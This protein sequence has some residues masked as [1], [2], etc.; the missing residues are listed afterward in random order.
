MRSLFRSCLWLLL[1]FAPLALAWSAPLVIPAGSEATKDITA[2]NGQVE[3]AGHARESVVL[4]GGRLK[5]TGT[6]DKDVICVG[7]D[8][9]IGES[10]IIGQDLIVIGGTLNKSDDCKI[11]GKSIYLRTRE[12]MLAFLQ[13]MLPFLPSAGGM[14]L[15]R[16]MKIVLFLILSLL[17]LAIVQNHVRQ[18]LTMFEGRIA[19]FTVIGLIGLVIF[20]MMLIFATILSFFLIG[21]PILLLLI[22]F[23]FLTLIFGRTVLLYSLGRRLARALS[24]KNLLPSYCIL[25]G[26]LIYAALKFVP[27][28]GPLILIGLDVVSIG[29]GTGYLF[30]KKFFN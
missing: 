14:S 10:A 6:V 21:I 23:Y 9:F 4:F 5:L 8:I 11:H 27:F 29:I 30:R 18:A 15:I 17:V 3:V 20:L 7:S 25:V 1:I 28:A 16:G 22:A 26:I 12:D 19:K 13:E 2:V 24:I